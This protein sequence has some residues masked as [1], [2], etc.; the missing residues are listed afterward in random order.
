M[1]D[2]VLSDKFYATMK[3]LEPRYPSKLALLLPALHAAQDEIGW[4]SSGVMDEVAEYIEIHPAQVREV[5]TFYSMY[6]FKPVGKYHIKVCT[7]VSCTLRGAERLLEHCEKKLGI[8]V[9]ETTPDKK[10]TIHEEE[11]LGACG[12]APAMMINEDY[13][14][15][16][17]VQKLDRILDE[18]E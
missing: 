11:C 4:L 2:K 6:N 10:F 8:K 9:A 18:L 3:K 1:A 17:D 16:L 14:E 15:N 7:N 13:H 12:T 5:A